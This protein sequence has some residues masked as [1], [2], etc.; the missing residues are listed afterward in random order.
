MRSRTRFFSAFGRTALIL[1]SLLAACQATQAGTA[2]QV[3]KLGASPATARFAQALLTEYVQ[4]QPGEIDE[5]ITILP[6]TIN[7]DS[8]DSGDL[9]GMV[10][11]EDAA[12]EKDWK[13]AIGWLALTFAVNPANPVRDLSREALRDI[14][15]GRV[16][17]WNSLGGANAPIARYAGIPGTELDR[18]FIGLVLDHGRMASDVL[19]A[20]G[21]WAMQDAALKDPYG[22][23]QMVCTESLAGIQPLTVSGITADF[24]HAMD[25][26]YPFGFRVLLAA[27]S[28]ANESILRFAAWAQS[29]AG[30]AVNATSCVAGAG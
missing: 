27:R 2:N 9:Q 1:G 10:L 24:T 13:A 19:I 21:F 20:P 8:L 3:I 11:M 7:W 5:Q 26:R 28:P 25:G 23:V 14:Y 12:P 6:E 15:Q 22:L 29:A 4:S 18:V 16:T 17:N 30:E